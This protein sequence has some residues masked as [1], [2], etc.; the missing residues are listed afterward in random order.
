MELA[1]TIRD[2]IGTESTP[3]P[4][5]GLKGR[6]FGAVFRG[7][8]N[9]ERVSFVIAGNEAWVD[10]LPMDK[11]RRDEL[12]DRFTQGATADRIAGF[13]AFL[14]THTVTDFL[15]WTQAT[16]KESGE[17]HWQQVRPPQGN[18]QREDFWRKG[19]TL[20]PDFWDAL[21][22]DCLRVNGLG[23]SAEGNSETPSEP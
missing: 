13:N 1:P 14:A 2:Q 3:T 18:Q 23:Q 11:N 12:G 16:D 17:K 4:P 22:A 15:L 5:P 21:L 6:T 20:F 19:A 8:R 7:D 10:L 9:P